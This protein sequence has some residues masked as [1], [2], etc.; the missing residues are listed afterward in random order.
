[1]MEKCCSALLF[2]HG[3]WRRENMLQALFIF[4]AEPRFR[5]HDLVCFLSLLNELRKGGIWNCLKIWVFLVTFRR[6]NYSKVICDFFQVSWNFPNFL[7]LSS[8]FAKPAHSLLPGGCLF[9]L[10]GSR[11]FVV[12][13]AKQTVKARKT[14]AT[15]FYYTETVNIGY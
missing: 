14:N 15:Q 12:C 11:Q 5:F 1:M 3:W 8:V 10:S 9:I 6:I 4:A 7:F 13:L 2:P